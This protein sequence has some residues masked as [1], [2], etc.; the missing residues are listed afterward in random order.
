MWWVL[1]W[2]YFWVIS[3][4]IGALAG[5]YRGRTPMGS[6][7]GLLLGPMGWFIVLLMDDIRTKCKLCKGVIEP[8]NILCRHCGT[9]LEWVVKG[10]DLTQN[11]NNNQ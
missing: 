10:H 6:M 5:R 1:L 8:A 4:L 7:L 2:L 9:K 11:Y 3:I